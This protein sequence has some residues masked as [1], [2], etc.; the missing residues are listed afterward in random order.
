MLFSQ[1]LRPFQFPKLQSY[2]LSQFDSSSHFEHG[3]TGTLA[4]VNVN[5]TIW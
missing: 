4:H 5:L 3:L 2:R 1:L